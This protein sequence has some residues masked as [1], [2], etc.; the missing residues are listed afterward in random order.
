MTEAGFKGWILSALRSLT[1]KW[2]PASDAWNINT[3]AKPKS[4]PG[5]HRIEHQCAHCLKWGPRKTKKNTWGIELDHLIPIGGY[6]HGF[7]AWIVKA[8]VE[9]E[10][11]QKLCTTCH[12]IKTNKEKKK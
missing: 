12:R 9:V 8:F 11:F 1:R 10:G 6:K 7:D 5:R 2:K 4:V 3:R